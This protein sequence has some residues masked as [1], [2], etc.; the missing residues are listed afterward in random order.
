MQLSEMK[1]EKGRLVL[2]KAATGAKAKKV[3]G[4]TYRVQVGAY[5][6]PLKKSPDDYFK[7]E[8]IEIYSMNDAITRYVTPLKFT[9]IK[10]A[11]AHKKQMIAKGVKDSWIVSFYNGKRISVQETLELLQQK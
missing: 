6:K 5:S 11:E 8:G 3:E 7:F 10:S 2:E 9:D 1:D 4:L